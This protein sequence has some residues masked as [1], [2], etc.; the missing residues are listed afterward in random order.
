MPW[1]EGCHC[2]AGGRGHAWA[3]PCP[4]GVPEGAAGCPDSS[5]T[6]GPGSRCRRAATKCRRIISKKQR[7]EQEKQ[8]AEGSAL[9]PG[10][11]QSRGRDPPQLRA[12][13]PT[14]RG[15]DRL[16]AAAPG[17]SRARGS[18]G[19]GRGWGGGARGTS[20]GNQKRL[21]KQRGGGSPS[22]LCP[23]LLLSSRSSDA[24]CQ[25]NPSPAGGVSRHPS[26]PATRVRVSGGGPRRLPSQPRSSPRP[27][28]AASPPAARGRCPRRSPGR[29]RL[30]LSRSLLPCSLL[31]RPSPPSFS[32]PHSSFAFC[33]HPFP[34]ALPVALRHKP[35]P[36]L[37]PA[38]PPSA[39]GSRASTR[40]GGERGATRGN[41]GQ[42]GPAAAAFRP[43][44]LPAAPPRI[45]HPAGGRLGGGSP[46]KGAAGGASGLGT[47]DGEAE[48]RNYSGAV[49]QTPP[50]R[51]GGGETAGA[52]P[53][54]NVP[55]ASRQ[56]GGPGLGC[57]RQR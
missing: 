52:S 9:C 27:A 15:R 44:P 28:P 32:L 46:C 54:R 17:C 19:A 57:R 55:G 12:P 47:N 53:G 34:R 8:S 37:P 25:Q 31:S 23:A 20:F 30:C 4:L 35:P 33:P 22:R 11:G 45:R 10:Q 38:V 21:E 14:P 40:P 24:G 7:A 39:G 51:L 5:R 2:G 43:A 56:G 36:G 1:T 3:S 6:A 48:E 16:G 50:A 18:A 41:G 26:P 29:L 49:P 13:R 42:R